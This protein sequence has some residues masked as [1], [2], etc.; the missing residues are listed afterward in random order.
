MSTYTDN[1]KKKKKDYIKIKC[2]QEYNKHLDHNKRQMQKKRD[3]FEVFTF[4]SSQITIIT[5]TT[6]FLSITT[7]I[8]HRTKNCITENVTNAVFFPDRPL[9]YPVICQ[10]QRIVGF[11]SCQTL[12]FLDVP[13][14]VCS[15]KIYPPVRYSQYFIQIKL[16]YIGWFHTHM[17]KV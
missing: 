3:N 9:A 7:F 4:I 6:Y 1:S 5:I 14:M 11:R 2:T 10:L 17:D 13:Q 16:N 12:L 15:D 8:T